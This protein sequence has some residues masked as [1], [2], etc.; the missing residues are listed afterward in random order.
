MLGLARFL[1]TPRSSREHQND[2]RVIMRPVAQSKRPFVSGAP[3]VMFGNQTTR[4]F[5]LGGRGAGN[6]YASS[7]WPSSHGRGPSRISPYLAFKIAPAPAA[8]VG[9]GNRV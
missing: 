1:R 6:L 7:A 4:K 9:A 8:C 5:R 2:R 3:P